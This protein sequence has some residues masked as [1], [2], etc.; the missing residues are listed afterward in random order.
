MKLLLQKYIK[1]DKIPFS[2]IKPSTITGNHYPVV[3]D[4]IEKSIKKYGWNPVFKH[5]PYH[6]DNANYAHPFLLFELRNEPNIYHLSN[7]QHRFEVLKKLGYTEISG[8]ISTYHRQ[9]KHSEEHIS[10]IVEQIKLELKN[11][12]KGMFQS[13]EFDYG[14]QLDCRDKSNKFFHSTMWHKPYWIEKDVLDIACN[15]GYF[16]YQTKRYGAKKVVAFDHDAYMINKAKQ[17]GGLLDLKIDDLGVKDFWKFDWNQKFD[18]VFCNQCIYHFGNNNKAMEA[19]DLICDATTNNLVM[20]T[21]VDPN[22]DKLISDLSNGYRPGHKQ[23]CHD[24]KQRGFKE[25]L[26]FHDEGGKRTVV[27]SKKP[28]TYLHNKTI[29]PRLEYMETTV[30]DNNI[31]KY[32]FTKSADELKEMW[33]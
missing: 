14:V 19:L 12:Q 13:F 23:I 22:N 30:K 1:V 26:I 2:K 15:G 16:A 25:I 3:L 29:Y 8:Y 4:E 7:S 10:V 6:G 24:L 20:F 5:L 33:Y 17:F 27:A 28:W 32:W 11:N 9:P 31:Y 21:F 18:I